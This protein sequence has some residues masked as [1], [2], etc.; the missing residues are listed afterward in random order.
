MK[1]KDVLNP[2]WPRRSAHNVVGNERISSAQRNNDT[3]T[4]TNP[5]P[6]VPDEDPGTGDTTEEDPG[7][8]DTTDEDIDMETSTNPEPNVPDDE[9]ADNTPNHQLP[10]AE[11]SD[12]QNTG[13]NQGQERRRYLRCRNPAETGRVRCRRCLRADRIYWR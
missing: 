11:T 10:Q 6:D 4:S 7:T 8:G 13:S 5:E 2:N 1:V 9:P 3:E 12:A